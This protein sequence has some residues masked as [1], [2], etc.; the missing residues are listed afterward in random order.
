MPRAYTDSKVPN[1]PSCR[2]LS[3]ASLRPVL[4]LG[5]RHRHAPKER[6]SHA[7]LPFIVE[8]R[9]SDQRCFCCGRSTTAA[10][11]MLLRTSH[12]TPCTPPQQLALLV[13]PS[14]GAGATSSEAG[15]RLHLRPPAA[16]SRLAVAFLSG[17]WSPSS[18]AAGHFLRLAAWAGGRLPLG[19]AASRGWRLFR[20]A[21]A[22]LCACLYICLSTA[23]YDAARCCML[24][25]WSEA[26]MRRHSD[27]KTS[28]RLSSWRCAL[29][30]A[31]AGSAL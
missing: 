14:S 12:R 7:T 5:V 11:G 20:R 4:A 3:D 9:H 16:F 26:H 17:C 24:D 29:L 28:S 19:L 25:W 1:D 10:V 6:A 22:R 23:M 8:W 13:P 18:E 2:N 27:P 15:G 30:S 21:A 31:S